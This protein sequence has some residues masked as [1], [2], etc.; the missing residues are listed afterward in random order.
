MITFKDFIISEATAQKK[1]KMTVS[2]LRSIITGV[3]D[4]TSHGDRQF[5]V[6]RGFYYKSGKTVEHFEKEIV[7]QLEKEG[8]SVT[9]I[10]SGEIEKPFK[11]GASTKNSSHWWIKLKVE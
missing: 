5:T 8:Y 3:D 6:R 9:V 7:S 4:A 10:D 11:G 1:K 2:L